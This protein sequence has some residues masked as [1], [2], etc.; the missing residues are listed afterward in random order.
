MA[1][2]R[3]HFFFLELSLFLFF[4]LLFFDHSKEVVAFGF[5]L[6][7]HHGFT[8]VELSLASELKFCGDPY[9]LLSCQ[10]LFATLLAFAFLKGTLGTKCVDL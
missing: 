10:L 9:V 6:V 2:E 4:F 7:G 1:F 3:L 5:G 8:L